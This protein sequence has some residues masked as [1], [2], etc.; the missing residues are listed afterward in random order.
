VVRS[1]V[2]DSQRGD[3][4]RRVR[5]L[6]DSQRVGVLGTRF[7]G[8]PHLSLV[9]FAVSDDLREITFASPSGT[10]KVAAIRIDPCVSLLVDDREHAGRDLDAGV[11]LTGTGRAEPLTAA[12]SS[13]VVSRYLARHPGLAGFVA[14]P[15]CRFFRIRVRRW[16][17]VSRFQEVEEL[18]LD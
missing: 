8:A 10:R 11:A 15:S 13:A 14:A 18:T 4:L 9:A 2:T 12:E 5:E 7:E 3:F 17:L 1:A 16:S 6:L